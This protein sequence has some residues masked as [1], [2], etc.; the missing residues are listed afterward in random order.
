MKILTLLTLT[1]L[2]ATCLFANI[3]LMNA[4]TA[5]ANSVAIT[6]VNIDVGMTALNCNQAIET[7]TAAGTEKNEVTTTMLSGATAATNQA[8]TWTRTGAPRKE[9]NHVTNITN[10]AGAGAGAVFKEA[11]GF[12]PMKV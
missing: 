8:N 7:A 5:T 3:N 10:D 11:I 9:P 2:L 4:N 12:A 6:A 1:L